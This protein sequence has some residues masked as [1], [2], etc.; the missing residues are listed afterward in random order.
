MSRTKGSKNKTLSKAQLIEGIEE[1]GL[2][3]SFGKLDTLIIAPKTISNN[4]VELLKLNKGF[5]AVCNN[6]NASTMASTPLRLYAKGNASEKCLFPHK[7]LNSKEIENVKLSSGSLS[8]KN[9]QNIVEIYEHPVFDVLNRFNDDLNYHDGI[10]LTAQYLGMMGN[11]MWQIIKEDGLPKNIII[12]P[13]E[14]TTVTLTEDMHIKGYRTFNGVYQKD[15][16]TDEVIHFKNMAPGLFWRIWNQGL[17]TGLYGQGDLEA[18][19]DEVYLYNAINDYLRALTENNA[20]PS[21]IIKYKNGRLDKQTMKDLESDWNKV[22]RSWKKAGKTKV[23]DEDFDFVPMGYNPKDL[24]FS[25]G[26]KWLRGVI[27]NAFGVP[28]DLITTENSNKGSSNTAIDHYARFTIRPK[29]KRLEDKLNSHLMPMY[30]DDFFLQYDN[31]IPEDAALAIKEEEMHLI[32]GVITINEVRRK[33]GLSDVEW[34]DEPFI[35][36]REMIRDN[37]G[38]DGNGANTSPAKDPSKVNEQIAK[39]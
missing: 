29:L 26:R 6:K 39:E 8:V 13:S 18:V 38:L 31:P 27:G 4:P 25:E 12:L 34:G 10:E 16:S 36:K 30:D 22:M 7:Q 23:M 15:Y 14:Y 11:C 20:I 33:S 5:V 24:D 19:L 35:P 28:E 3:P 21:G 2:A 37:A 17:I 9:A 32:Q 1:K